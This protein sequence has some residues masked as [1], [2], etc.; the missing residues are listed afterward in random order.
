MDRDD[1]YL[2][3]RDEKQPKVLDSLFVYKLW[4]DGLW[5]HVT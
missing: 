4:M 1:R 3:Q 2:E 5:K